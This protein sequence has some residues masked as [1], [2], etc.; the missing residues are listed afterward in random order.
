MKAVELTPRVD[1]VTRTAMQTTQRC[2]TRAA[3]GVHK[4]SFRVAVKLE[5]LFLCANALHLLQQQFVTRVRKS[6]PFSMLCTELTNAIMRL[7]THHQRGSGW[8]NRG[9]VH[10]HFFSALTTDPGR[11]WAYQVGTCI[12]FVRELT[13]IGL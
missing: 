1:G 9:G 12:T 11:E 13:L 4:A 3:H 5:R 6:S 2:T 8:S 10:S 7:C